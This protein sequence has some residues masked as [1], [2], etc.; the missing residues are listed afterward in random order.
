MTKDSLS[1][2]ILMASKVYNK[3]IS[4]TDLQFIHPETYSHRSHVRR[5]LLYLSLHGLI[6]LNDDDTWIITD[7]GKL[8]LYTVVERESKKTIA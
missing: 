5:S 7:S 3:L 6:L 4:I 2:D 1:H 8:F